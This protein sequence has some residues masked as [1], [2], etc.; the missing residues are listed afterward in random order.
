MPGHL[1]RYDTGRCEKSRIFPSSTFLNLYLLLLSNAFFLVFF[2]KGSRISGTDA[3]DGNL[4]VSDDEASDE[5]DT[6]S[7]S[8]STGAASSAVHA[9]RLG[10]AAVNS[11][12]DLDEFKRRLLQETARM[13]QVHPN[14]FLYETVQSSFAGGVK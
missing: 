7:T 4:G 11:V 2:I 12:E 13:K 10:A 6:S 14:D 3:A 8:V 1:T 9:R 5:D